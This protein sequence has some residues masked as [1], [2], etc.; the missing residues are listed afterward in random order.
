MSVV[1]RFYKEIAFFDVDL[2]SLTCGFEKLGVYE[3]DNGFDFLLLDILVF[4]AGFGQILKLPI[5]LN[6]ISE[7]LK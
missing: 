7:V 4:K 6:K 5:F 1:D 2:D 3:F